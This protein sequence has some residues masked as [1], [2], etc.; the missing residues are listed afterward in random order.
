[1]PG[2]DAL[3]PDA[4]PPRAAPD[5][6]APD[7]ATQRI[8]RRSVLGGVALGVVLLG[9]VG[10][11]LAPHLFGSDEAP[12]LGGPFALTDD[13]GHAVT[14][15]TYR[16]RWMLVY[17]GYT[18]CPDACPT[19][20]NDVA[21]ALDLLSPQQRR[22]VAPLFITLDPARDTPAVMHDYVAAFG[23]GITG[24]TGSEPQIAEAEKEYRVYAAKH[25]EKNGDYSMDHSDI[26]YLMNPQGRFVSI[27]NG[28]ANPQEIAAKL[29]A[30]M[31]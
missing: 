8:R 2:P 4:P 3:P 29:K 18:H 5:G 10:V 7:D 25:P 26:I 23:T 16:G 27:V 13:S 28:G 9:A 14:Q 24:L 31:G 19:A 12:Q 22:E 17:F 15:D 6:A 1:M 21:N 20:L 30:A 11:A